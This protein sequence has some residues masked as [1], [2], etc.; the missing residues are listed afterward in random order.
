MSL[1]EVEMTLQ[2][3]EDQVKTLDVS[4]GLAASRDERANWK[5]LL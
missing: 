5:T 4:E 3:G 2:K 1:G